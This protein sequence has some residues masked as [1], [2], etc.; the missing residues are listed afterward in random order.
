MQRARSVIEIAATPQRVYD[1]VAD[2]PRHPEWAGHKLR[3][4]H[5]D[6]PADAAGGRFRSAGVQ[7]GREVINE[8]TVVEAD[9][10]RRFVFDASG[11][12]GRFRHAYEIEPTATGSRLTRTMEVM[13]ASLPLKLL[14]ASFNLF[15]A[16]RNDGDLARLKARLES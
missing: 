9:P 8:L 2:L 15:V 16:K 14:S 12:E 7:L 11:K 1:Y 13:D 6:G 4:E 3:V 10:P 5:V